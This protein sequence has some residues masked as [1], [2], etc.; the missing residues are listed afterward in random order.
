MSTRITITR[1]CFLLQTN[2][3]P[4]D[5]REFCA[6]FDGASTENTK[7]MI[8]NIRSDLNVLM[9]QRVTAGKGTLSV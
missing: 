5:K 7:A 2:V 4:D 9:L 3:L 1:C 6:K 8:A